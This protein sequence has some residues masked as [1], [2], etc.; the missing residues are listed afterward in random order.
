MY[1]WDSFE[2]QKDPHSMHTS[3]PAHNPLASSW[4]RQ[5]G[6]E[7]ADG[8][9]VT[10]AQVTS[11]PSWSIEW[12]LNSKMVQPSWKPLTTVPKDERVSVSGLCF[13]SVCLSCSSFF[14]RPLP[15]SDHPSV[16]QLQA[17][18]L[19][20]KPSYETRATG[21]MTSGLPFNPEETS[22]DHRQ[23]P[24]AQTEHTNGTRRPCWNQEAHS[25][26]FLRP[27]N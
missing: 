3:A 17:M 8:C 19:T 6:S 23:S 11:H 2:T 21:G 16:S 5:H 25:Y 13:L 27:W 22:K 24:V 15:Q 20:W 18:P 9:F 7:P 4:P 26:Y 10:T 14:F 1:P 12:E